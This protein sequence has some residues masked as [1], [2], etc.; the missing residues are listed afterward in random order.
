MNSGDQTVSSSA[1]ATEARMAGMARSEAQAVA[2]AAEPQHANADIYEGMNGGSIPGLGTYAVPGFPG[3]Q[4]IQPGGGMAPFHT[5]PSISPPAISGS[6]I[7]GTPAYPSGR[8]SFQTA[9]TGRE[10]MQHSGQQ[11][12]QPNNALPASQSASE[13]RAPSPSISSPFGF[14]PPGNSPAA[15]QL[16]LLAAAQNDPQLWPILAAMSRKTLPHI[17]RAG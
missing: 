9:P 5:G 12:P 16:A 8:N 13:V 7:P 6:Q 2:P 15:T 10:V 14:N 17:R 4:P 1:A 3:N 11:F